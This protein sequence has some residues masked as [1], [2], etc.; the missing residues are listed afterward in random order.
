MQHKNP[1]SEDTLAGRL[2]HWVTG[3]RFDA[4]SPQTVKEAKRCVLD[5]LGVQVRGATLPWVQPVYRYVRSA[6]GRQEATVT[7]HGDRAEAPYA[8]Y[9]NS[10]FS[11]SCELQ[12]HG[13]FGSAHTGVIV[14]PVIQALG[15][16]KATP[17]ELEKI[18][19]LLNNLKNQ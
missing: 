10:A 17:E 8:A 14:V 5:T 4:L 19:A 7:Y 18:Q 6:G 2:A 16:H 9:A 12:H 13:T 1:R 3:L 11:Y 15:E